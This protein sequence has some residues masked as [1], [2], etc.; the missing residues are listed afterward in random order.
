MNISVQNAAITPLSPKND[1]NIMFA[2]KQIMP[3]KIN[4]INI[5]KKL[6]LILLR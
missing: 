6:H 4:K 2:P 1:M 3:T 5:F